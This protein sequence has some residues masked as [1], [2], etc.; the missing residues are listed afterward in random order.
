MRQTPFAQRTCPLQP[1]EDEPQR[2]QEE[3]GARATCN[4]QHLLAIDGQIVAQ[5]AITRTETNHVGTYQPTFCQEEAIQRDGFLVF[6]LL[7]IGS[8][9]G[10]ID[11]ESDTRKSKSQPEKH[12]EVV[13]VFI[14]KDAHRGGDGGGK[15]VAQTEIADSLVSTTRGHHVNHNRTAGHRCGSK[16]NS[17]QRPHNGEQQQRACQQIRTKEQEIEEKAHKQH[18]LAW[19]AVGQIAAE[20]THEESRERVTRKHQP[21]HVFR[22]I[23]IVAQI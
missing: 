6:Q 15:I 23:E 10:G 7:P 4:S 3:E 11:G 19:E 16:R 5:D 1:R 21:Y 12:I 18:A 20:R 17:M 13:D 9:E 14:D 2:K 8:L 22:S